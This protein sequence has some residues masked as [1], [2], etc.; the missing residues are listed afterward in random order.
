M[1]LLVKADLGAGETVEREGENP[2]SVRSDQDGPTPTTWLL[3]R[4]LV[5]VVFARARPYAQPRPSSVTHQPLRVRLAASWRV[6]HS[7]HL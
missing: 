6:D 5:C 1:F 2:G 7:P 3:T 4:G